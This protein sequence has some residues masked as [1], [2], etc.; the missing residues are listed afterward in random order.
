MEKTKL[1]GYARVSTKKDDQKH[2]FDSQVHYFKNEVVAVRSEYKNCEMV[3]VYADELTATKF[4]R[5]N[6][7]KMIED[8]G[9]D[10]DYKDNRRKKGKMRFEASLDRE[11]K[12]NR[13]LVTNISRL[14]RDVVII[15]ILRELVKKNVYV[16]FLENNWTTE[17]KAHWMFIEMFFSFSE[18]ES[19]DRSSKV[20]EGLNKTARRG[21]LFSV[22]NLYGY[23]YHNMELTINEQEAVVVRT[24]FTMYSEGI[25]TRRIIKHLTDNE[26]F[27]RE[28]KKFSDATLR[29]MLKNEKYCGLLY[30]NK[31]NHGQIHIWQKKEIKPKE[32]WIVPVDE[33][34]NVRDEHTNKIPAIISDELF[35]KVQQIRNSKISSITKKGIHSGISEYANMLVCAKCGS[36]MI[37]SARYKKGEFAYTIYKCSNKKNNGKVACDLKD[38]RGEH[39]EQALEQFR[40]ENVIEIVN[41]RKNYYISRLEEERVR[42]KKQSNHQDNERANGLKLELD[43]LEEQKK[44]LAY[45]FMTG[46]FSESQLNE[47]SIEINKKIESTSVLYKEASITS[48]EIE[49]ILAN[50]DE[51]IAEVVA[52]KANDSV[53]ILELI[54]KVYIYNVTE[55]TNNNE[56]LFFRFQLNLF[57][58][59]YSIIEKFIDKNSIE[60]FNTQSTI[61]IQI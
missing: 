22:H 19:R 27:T 12:F 7:L 51:I 1:V 48:D 55:E 59:L 18:Q 33:N 50:I 44:K 29:G 38:I 10:I 23:N 16:D 41:E 49:K 61:A 14:S 46:N 3:N 30:R 37:R 15:D 6:F 35:D 13:V 39:L 4:L 17:N 9:V 26:H 28:G 47:M 52:F 32:E 11:A 34:G 42:I 24:I 56:I 25:G 43:N 5:K 57:D 2:S 36:S 45:L 54:H 58:S 40:N 53:D 60:G 21:K 20:S 31:H 8:A